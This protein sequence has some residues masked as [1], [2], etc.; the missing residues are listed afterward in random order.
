[1][2]EERLDVHGRNRHNVLAVRQGDSREL[3]E[4]IREIAQKL[5]K[6][7]S[8][9]TKLGTAARYILNHFDK[10]TAY[11]DDPRLEPTNNMR[12]RM[13]RTEK[14]IENSLQRSLK[15]IG[16]CSPKLID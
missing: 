9:A 3:W 12:E 1:M 11:L 13:L 14:L 4:Q 8:K 15:L 16:V 7:W 6:R 2:H 5:E 10:L